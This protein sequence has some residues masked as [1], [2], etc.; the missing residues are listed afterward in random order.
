MGVRGEREHKFLTIYPLALSQHRHQHD[1]YTQNGVITLLCISTQVIACLTTAACHTM[2][3]D[4]HVVLSDIRTDIKK[5]QPFSLALL[6]LKRGCFSKLRHTLSPDRPVVLSD[7]RI[8]VYKQQ[9]WSL[10]LL[11]LGRGSFSEEGR[12]RTCLLLRYRM[13]RSVKQ[14][15]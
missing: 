13:T 11:Y 4:R 12:S 1:F 7:I 3:L 8:D 14:G 6:H 15:S 2:S 10:A 9:P 5:Q